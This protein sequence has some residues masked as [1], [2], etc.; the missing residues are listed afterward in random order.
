MWYL[1]IILF[2]TGSILFYARRKRKISRVKFGELADLATILSLLAAVLIPILSNTKPES[3]TPIAGTTLISNIPSPTEII[4]TSQAPK[5]QQSP[6]DITRTP[7]TKNTQTYTPENSQSSSED[8][9]QPSV[10]I[11]KTITSTISIQEYTTPVPQFM[12]SR[13]AFSGSENNNTDIFIIDKDGNN[14]ERIT[15]S[16][17]IDEMPAW[18][19][20]GK[21]IAFIS[22]RGGYHEL[23][24]I[25]IANEARPEVCLTNNNRLKKDP[26][27]SP[28]G[29]YIAFSEITDLGWDIFLVDPN[30][31]AD[32][33]Q[34]T[35]NTLDDI[36]PSWSP[37]GNNIIFTSY[38]NNR[39]Q[40]MIINISSM[41]ITPL[42]NYVP[43]F[44]QFEPS[45][46]PEGNAIAFVESSST[47]DAVVG[48][49]IC[50]IQIIKDDN[51][52]YQT[53]K[54]DC[55][56]NIGV[57]RSPDWSPSGKA[58]VFVRRS[59]GVFGVLNLLN[60][61]TGG[62]SKIENVEG[63]YPNWGTP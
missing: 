47:N 24:V 33:I 14:K 55:K 19:P 16:K 31:A 57:V 32:E 52:D 61:R 8:S 10:T 58:I 43:I 38:L 51:S 50:V 49:G 12:E 6:R 37:D 60:L 11:T 4:Q 13:I 53:G 27:W 39:W 34:L 1:V 26:A 36:Q 28:D 40:L 7:S 3:L 17:E 48:F 25:D 46:S 21:K 41:E 59:S 30:N 20:D 45:W 18:S 35:Q 5:A 23:W 62:I 56:E 54:L 29:K 15:T 63:N 42:F 22:L 2:L 44:H 9:P